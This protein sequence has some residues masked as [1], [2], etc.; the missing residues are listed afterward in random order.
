MNSSKEHKP[1][2]LMIVSRFPYPLDKGDKLRAFYQLRELSK[3]F[4]ITLIALTSKNTSKEHL[5]KVAVFCDEVIISKLSWTSKL[6]HM[7][8]SFWNGKPFQVGYFYSINTQKTIN[9]TLKKKA[10]KHI[11]CQLVRTTEYVKNVHH[12]PK[13]LDYMD[14]LST[15]IE[16]R[17]EKQPFYKKWL[18]KSESKRLAKYERSIFDFFEHKTIISEQDRALIKH[19]DRDEIICVSNGIDKSFF[20]EIDTEKDHDFVFVGNMSYPPNIE[21]VHYIHDNILPNFPNSKLLVSGS[22]PHISLKE[23]ESSSSQITL[24][25]WIDDIRDSYARGKV[26]LAPMMIGTG[27]QNKLLEA[28][29]LRIPCITTPLANNAI[30]AKHESQI[31]EGSTKEELTNLAAQLLSNEELQQSIGQSGKQFVKAHYSWE[32]SSSKLVRL[33]K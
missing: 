32:K 27:M 16:R 33:I 5:K 18:F 7:G 21:A 31:L 12:I 4:N 30:K 24:T 3:T 9:S 13:T 26:F 28:M 22:S 25:G 6:I 23:L 20:E 10:F 8:R 11:Y 19:P 1:Q 15:G 29:A 2:L 17:I 14:A